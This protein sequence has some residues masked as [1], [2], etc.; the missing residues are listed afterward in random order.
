MFILPRFSLFTLCFHGGLFIVF[1]SV[2]SL[3]N[4]HTKILHYEI[5]IDAVRYF[6]E[7]SVFVST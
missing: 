4:P 6:W 3:R 5:K 7:V 1:A 2:N